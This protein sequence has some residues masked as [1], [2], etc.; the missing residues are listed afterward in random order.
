MSTTGNG[1]PP[2]RKARRAVK[3]RLIVG[4]K[5]PDA[6]AYDLKTPA[7]HFAHSLVMF[8]SMYRKQHPGLSDANLIAACLQ[9]SASVAI[10]LEDTSSAGFS[11]A[12]AHFYD[13]EI[14]AAIAAGKNPTP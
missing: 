12:A 6:L 5:K 2:N 13:G 14:Q 3:F 1:R 10:R 8:L 4:D 11:A 7:G 9:V